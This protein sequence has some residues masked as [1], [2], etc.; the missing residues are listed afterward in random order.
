M[1]TFT[2]ARG[3]R[4]DW[5]LVDRSRCAARPTGQRRRALIRGKHKPTVHA[6]HGRGDFV[7]VVNVRESG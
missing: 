4:H 2:H 3:S 7:I 6:P 5:H 1:K